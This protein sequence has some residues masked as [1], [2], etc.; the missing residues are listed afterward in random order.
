MNNQT[1]ATSSLMATVSKTLVTLALGAL[2]G[3]AIYAYFFAPSDVNDV[4]NAADSGQ[5]VGEKSTD[6]PLYW[7]A[8]MDPNFRRDKPGKSPMGMDLVPVYQEGSSES[9][10]GSVKISPVVVQNL[11]VR[12]AQLERGTLKPVINAVGRVQYDEER[13][14]HVH[15]RIAGWVEKLYVK[16]AGEEV[17][18][19]EPLYQLYS[20]ELV[21]AQEEFLLAIN[22]KD[23]ELIKAAESRLLAL[24]VPMSL[25]EKLTKT[26]QVDQYVSFAAPQSGVIEHLSIREGYYVTPEKTMLSIADL[27]TVWVEAEVLERQAGFVLSAMNTEQGIGIKAVM[28]AD[29]APN[30]E[31]QG[32][33]DYIYPSLH[34]VRRTLRTRL[35]FDNA[36]GFLKANMFT[37]VKLFVESDEDYLLLPKAALIRLGDESRAVVQ[38]NEGEFKSVRVKVGAFDDNYFAITSG[39]KDDDSVVIS[40]QF[41]IDSQSSIDSDFMRMKPEEQPVSSA[42]VTGTINSLDSVARIA[43]IS[44]GAIE[45]WQRPPTT[46]DFSID[47]ALEL[48]LFKIGEEIDFTF[49]IQSGDFVVVE[50]HGAVEETKQHKHHQ[51]LTHQNLSPKNLSPQESQGD[52]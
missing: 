45:K 37:D 33:V 43:N 3:V 32:V 12:T 44:R 14:V 10:A 27:S 26:K 4:S 34:E 49:E 24:H 2:L 18:K 48:S 17:T 36:N 11:G 5:S 22:A 51:H 50:I 29:F 7:V 30:Q 15:P 25:I 13:L 41:L 39:L 47:E 31:W 20:P 46:M 16:A 38:L 52:S 35:K 28:T 8:P 40:A 42:R 9:V 19:G 21:N 6:E 1:N 23:K